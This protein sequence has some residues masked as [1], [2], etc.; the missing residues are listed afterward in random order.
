MYMM[1][2]FNREGLCYLNLVAKY[3][4]GHVLIIR[5]IIIGI[6][7][8]LHNIYCSGSSYFFDK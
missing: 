8:S 4:T 7:R 6:G 5:K 2:R 1:N 3:I